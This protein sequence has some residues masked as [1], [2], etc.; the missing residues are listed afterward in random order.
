MFVSEVC[1]LAELGK[2]TYHVHMTRLEVSSK[3]VN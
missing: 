2:M 1:S 3:V